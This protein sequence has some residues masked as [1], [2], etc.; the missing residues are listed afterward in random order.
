MT[1]IKNIRI[2]I[3]FKQYKLRIIIYIYIYKARTYLNE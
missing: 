2:K 1:I 3:S